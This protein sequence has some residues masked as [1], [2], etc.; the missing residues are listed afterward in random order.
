MDDVFTGLAEDPADVQGGIV[1]FAQF[2][3]FLVL[4]QL[5]VEFLLVFVKF[6]LSL[7]QPLDL[8]GEGLIFPLERGNLAG[9]R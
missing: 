7:D 9:L 1:F 4:L 6:A 5:D 3:E 2:V 8:L